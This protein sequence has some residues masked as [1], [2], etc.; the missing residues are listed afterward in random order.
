[1]EWVVKDVVT[2]QYVYQGHSGWS[3]TYSGSLAEKFTS[4]EKAA[5]ARIEIEF[6]GDYTLAI[7]AAP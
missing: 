1:M 7:E 3:F 2:G 5:N 4:Y 6:M